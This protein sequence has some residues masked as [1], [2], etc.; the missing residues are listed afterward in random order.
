MSFEFTYKDFGSNGKNFNGITI[1]ITLIEFAGLFLLFVRLN[2]RTIDVFYDRDGSWAIG[3]WMILLGIS[4][5]G[6]CLRYALT[7]VTA[8]YYAWDAWLAWRAH[9]P[10]FIG[11]VLA[12]M[13][14]SI[15]G[16]CGAAALFYWFIK[17]RDI[18]PKMFNWYVGI[19]LSS[20]ILLLLIY[21]LNKFPAS[22]GDLVGT[23][24]RSTFQTVIY[25][26]IWCTYLFRSDRSRATFLK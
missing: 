11:T 1:L 4:L 17:R 19:V 8:E 26:G 15:F 14:F 6:T 5:A 23:A 20:Q 18:F 7:L 3:G 24:L 22:Y 9:G 13:A 21:S 12:E 2:K 10:A 16:L 25:G